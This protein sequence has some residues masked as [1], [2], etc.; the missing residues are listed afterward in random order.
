[1]TGARGTL[2]QGCWVLCK[3]AGQQGCGDVAVGRPRRL[4][5][6]CRAWRV[7]CRLPLLAATEKTAGGANWQARCARLRKAKQERA[8]VPA[9]GVVELPGAALA[10]AIRFSHPSPATEQAGCAP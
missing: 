8:A 10:P 6:R 1:M 7:L 4:G 3:G 9:R 2:G 5:C